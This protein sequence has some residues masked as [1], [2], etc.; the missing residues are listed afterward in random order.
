MYRFAWLVVCL[1]ACSLR[2]FS[3]LASETAARTGSTD[4]STESAERLF[5]TK[6]LPLFSARCFGCHGKDAADIKGAFDMRS[7]QG[8]LDGGE[9]GEPA[10]VPGRPQDS[11]LWLATKWQGREMPPKKNDRLDRAQIQWLQGWIKAGAPW[12]EPQRIQELKR[13]PT[14]ENEDPGI[15]VRTSGGLTEEWTNRRYRA[16]HLWAL[17]PVQRPDV[18][19]KALPPS[20]TRHPIDAF[21]QQQLNARSIEPAGSAGRH[22]LLRRATLDLTGL[23]PTPGELDAFLRDESPRAFEAV[24]T[25][26]LDSPRYG[27]Q[28]AVQWLDVVRYADTAGYANDYERPHAW[29]YR[30]YVIRSF[31]QDKPYDQFVV[32]QIA[33]DELDA[34]NPEYLIGTGFLRMGPW[35]HTGMAVEAVTRQLFL[36]DVTNT[37]GQTFLAVNMTCL[38]CHDHK[39]DPFPTRDYYQMQS[40]FAPLQSGDRKLSF[41]R[42]ENTGSF[43]EGRD[44]VNQLMDEALAFQQRL[45]QKTQQAVS[46]LMRELGVE[47]R[48]EL[49]KSVGNLG[50][51][52]LTDLEKSLQKINNKRIAYYRRAVARFDPF[53]FSVYNGR[54]PGY[55]G[56][57]NQPTVRLPA[58]EKRRG[59]I[60]AIRILAGGALESPGESVAPGVISAVAGLSDSQGPTTWNSI[61]ASVN[62][63]RLALA[64]WIASSHNPL[65]ARVIVNRV[66]QHHFGRGI[67]ATPNAF[68]RMG[69][70]PTHPELLDWLATWFVERGWSLKRLHRLIMTSQAYQRTS[71]HPRHAQ[72]L[73]QDPN[74][75]LLAVF[76]ARRLRAEE[77]RDGLLA[78][79][80]E[81]NLAMGGPGIYPEI[82]WEVALQPRQI[83][84]TV[85]PAYQ[86]SRTAQQRNRRTIYAFRH[87]T[88][89]D[90]LLEV[91]NRPGSEFSCA[92]RDE[93]TVTPQ[94]LA[95]FNGQF[96]QD[97]A[98][99]L[100]S[101][102]M[103]ESP[104]AGERIALAIRRVYGRSARAAELQ[105]AARHVD[106]MTE[107]HRRHPTVEVPVPLSVKRGMVEE[108]TGQ[109][110]QYEDRL[111]LMNEYQPDLKSWQVSPE[112][113]ALAELCLVLM[114]SNEF[115]YVY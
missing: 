24:L 58:V 111:T 64:R 98:V 26:L 62:G 48:K 31:N 61:P 72:L 74:N 83:M 100:A 21:L 103:D 33:G 81:L 93:S 66:W 71:E 109:L 52:G 39:F 106:E 30:D 60:P 37:V 56:I 15:Q 95:W 1:W 112:T 99:A 78:I 44:R 22:Q 68:G 34:S 67:V 57:Q 59:P 7:R 10:L 94:V 104:D 40:V 65:T 73:A 108:L 80:G 75:E 92:T 88:L 101:R 115:M 63:R 32:E 45:K 36:D 51:Y 17:R 76:P 13:L 12:P 3:A 86:P 11:P 85:A 20:E 53:A 35:E 84:G 16:E 89:A 113:R 4:L 6:I 18:P 47:K 14:L 8:L 87:R 105:M 102:L 110:Y 70:R 27:E 43:E 49:P 46:Q 90:P 29:R 55:R 50:F 82:H 19:W 38:K 96:V 54:F 2:P 79:T 25:R 28:W 107:H 97:R 9:S 69:A 42:Y 114:N 5:A 41:Q 77:L 23:P 91:F